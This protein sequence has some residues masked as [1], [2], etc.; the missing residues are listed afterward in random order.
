MSPSSEPEPR[1]R[2]YSTSGICQGPGELDADARKRALTQWYGPV[3]SSAP[4]SER[5]VDARAGGIER[6]VMVNDADPAER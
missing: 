4:R 3:G 2:L 1:C 5:I 6:I